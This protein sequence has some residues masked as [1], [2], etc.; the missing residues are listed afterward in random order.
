MLLSKEEAQ[1]YD[2]QIRI[3]GFDAQKRI[4]STNVLII[5]VNALSVEISKNLVLA[6]IKTLTLLD[7]TLIN[8]QDI[9]RIFC[10][11]K[12]HEKS[13][14]SIALASYLRTLNPL[15][16]VRHETKFE[17]LDNLVKESNVVCCTSLL[18]G[19]SDLFQLNKL[20]REFKVPLVI[21]FTCGYA[22]LLFQDLGD[23]YEFSRENPIIELKSN[24]NHRVSAN[25]NP[26][27]F[28]SAKIKFDS[29]A[30]INEQYYPN[31]KRPIEGLS[32]LFPWFLYLINEL[33][34]CSLCGF[35]WHSKNEQHTIFRQ[36]LC[37]EASRIYGVSYVTSDR[38]LM[39]DC[40]IGSILGGIATQEI[41][42]VAT[43][44]QQPINNFFAF[45]GI[46]SIGI[47]QKITYDQ[48]AEIEVANRCEEEGF[49]E[50]EI[51]NG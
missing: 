10:F 37:H 31:P 49:V 47:A 45:D 34:K 30:S 9:Q 23:C 1:L 20:C 38:G 11:C 51:L 12:K 32:P 40:V 17:N 22:G 7:D 44:T 26:N 50:A 42:K 43:L 27:N 33:D 48:S 41:L 14:S 3:W 21:C 28:T 6:G 35:S 18:N 15:V 13:N 39:I 19:K 36:K 4:K 24:I 25:F 16:E 5:G 2:R 8:E 29:L 46:K